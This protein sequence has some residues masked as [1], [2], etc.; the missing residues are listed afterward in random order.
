M[1]LILGTVNY[2]ISRVD[3]SYTDIRARR[4]KYKELKLRSWALPDSMSLEEMKAYWDSGLNLQRALEV[5]FDP[6]RF[7]Q[8][9][10]FLRSLRDMSKMGAAITTLRHEEDQGKKKIV[11]KQD[12][13]ELEDWEKD[14]IEEGVSQSQEL[15]SEQAGAANALPAVL[16]LM[17]DLEPESSPDAVKIS[18]SLPQRKISKKTS[19]KTSKKAPKKA[20]KKVS[21]EKTSTLERRADPPYSIPGRSGGSSKRS[22]KEKRELPVVR[23]SKVKQS[24]RLSKDEEKALANIMRQYSA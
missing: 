9:D 20:L 2:K 1:L 24:Q 7:R 19:K 4:D 16:R 17:H 18:S 12:V 23:S 11:W 14:V 10:P 22:S 13:G 3:A 6:A 5:E 8:A 21:K 15:V